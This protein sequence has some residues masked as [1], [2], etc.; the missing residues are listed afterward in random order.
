MPRQL[1][2]VHDDPA[3]LPAPEPKGA[4]LTT[5]RPGD[6]GEWLAI[7]ATGELGDW[8]EAK[9][10]AELFEKP[11]F[12]REGCF[13]ARDPNS[14]EAL[15]TACAYP[16]GAFDRLW[17]GLHMV[18]ALPKARGRGLGKLVCQAV[19]H[20]W[21][22]HGNPR[23][24]LTTDDWRLPGIAAYLGLGWRPIRVREEG[25]DQAQRWEALFE[26][27]DTPPAWRRFADPLL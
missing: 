7:V 2:M 6:E 21:G 23:V 24:I 25:E 13:F 5:Y 17:P 8:D 4:A 19:A 9:A 1:L 22:R 20:Y 26:R 14:G 11:D 10:R 15:A 12:D 27:L 16:Q 18:G 3:S